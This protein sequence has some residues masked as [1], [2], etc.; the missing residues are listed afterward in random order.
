MEPLSGNSLTGALWVLSLTAGLI[1]AV[2]LSLTYLKLR[3]IPGP[4]F[5][6][7]SDLPRLYWTW[8]RKQ[9]EKH[10]DLHEKYGVLVRLGPNMVSVG[11]PA[12]I[13]II[14]GFNYDFQKSDFYKVILPYNNG[15]A[16]IGTISPLDSDLH[17]Q[18]K[19]PVAKIFS[20]SNLVTFESFVNSTMILFFDRLGDLYDWGTPCDLGT[21]L[22]WF[23]FD[24]LGELTFSKRYGFLE[25]AKDVENIIRD[26][27]THFDKVSLVGQMPWIDTK[28]QYRPIMSRI[29]KQPNSPQVD[30]QFA[31]MAERQAIAAK[32]QERETLNER[33]L[34]SWFMEAQM[35]DPT[36]PPWASVIW[37]ATNIG[38][39]SGPSATILRAVFYNLLKHPQTLKKLLAELDHAAKAGKLSKEANWKECQDLPYLDAC[40]KEAE[41][42][43]PAVGLPLERIVPPEGATICGHHFSGGTVVG[44]NAW[45]I[46][47]NKSIFGE[48]A[49]SWRPERWLCGRAERN[50]MEDT[51]LTFGA[52]SRVCYGNNFAHLIIYKLIASMLQAYDIQ[53]ADPNAEWRSEGRWFVV[54]KDFNVKLRRR[55]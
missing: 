40:V 7:L 17:R 11:D 18:I 49:A 30:F 3:S 29:F 4:F 55:V 36:L 5:A 48:D 31:R 52:G 16:M 8:T 45:V 26:V 46:H 28:L 51:L 53:L 21:W 43:H 38:A 22:E 23:V 32:P 10:I 14:Y 25:Q 15:V 39:G 47:Q 54:Q 1:W 50:K 20:M 33:D 12:A 13:P 27:E 44:M 9:F 24:A 6:A 19:K 42:I 2:Q 37:I 34:L 41:R 35:A